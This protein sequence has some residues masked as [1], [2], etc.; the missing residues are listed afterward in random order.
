MSLGIT[1]SGSQNTPTEDPVGDGGAESDC[2]SDATGT[3]EGVPVPGQDCGGEEE[4]GERVVLTP[5]T[6]AA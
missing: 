2:E 5:G 6:L 4:R 1:R 3:G